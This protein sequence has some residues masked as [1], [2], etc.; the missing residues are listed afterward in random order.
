MS[1][2]GWVGKSGAGEGG[3]EGLGD[4][5]DLREVGCIA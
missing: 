2:G 3:G 5:Y 1:F 4:E